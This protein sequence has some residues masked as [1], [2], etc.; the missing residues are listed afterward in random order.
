MNALHLVTENATNDVD[1]M[2][3]EAAVKSVRGVAGVASIRSMGLT[4]VLYDEHL[5]EDSQIV[6]AVRAVGYRPRLCRR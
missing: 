2:L 4:S 3:V 1:A 5:A 6:D